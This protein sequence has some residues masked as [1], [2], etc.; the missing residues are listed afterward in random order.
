MYCSYSSGCE[1]RLRSIIWLQLL[2][3]RCGSVVRG[4]Y[5]LH[6]F[7]LQYKH[8][9]MMSILGENIYNSVITL[10]YMALMYKPSYNTLVALPYIILQ[11]KAYYNMLITILHI[12]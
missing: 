3:H 8:V 10:P 9:L 11:Y 6:V 2:P 5:F 4:G 7:E 12:I 1:E